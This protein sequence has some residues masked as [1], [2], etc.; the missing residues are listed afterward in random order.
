MHTA[1][2][3][4]AARIQSGRRTCMQLSVLAVKSAAVLDTVMTADGGS[5]QPGSP[6]G[7]AP[8]Q[9]PISPG[10]SSRCQRNASERL[11]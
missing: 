4:L 5:R 7:T 11:L 6:G 2:G 1:S 8:P 10:A 3:Y 9:V